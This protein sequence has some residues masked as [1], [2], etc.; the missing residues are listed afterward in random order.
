MIPQRA[1]DLL[2]KDGFIAAYFEGVRAGKRCAEAFNR[3]NDEYK[4]YFGKYKY[5]SYR[6]FSEVRDYEQKKLRK[7][8]KNFR[9][10]K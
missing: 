9:W 6:S 3:V 2:D 8:A 1:I 7:R 5:A 10:D 4:S